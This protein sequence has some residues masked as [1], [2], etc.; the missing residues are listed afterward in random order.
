MKRTSAIAWL[1]VALCAEAASLAATPS[2]EVTITATSVNVAQPGAPVTIRILRWSTDAERAPI[3]NALNPPAAPA[4]PARNPGP[5]DAGRGRA[6]RGRGRGG[7]AATPL[8]PIAAFAAALGRA[9]TI[10]YIWT[11]DITGYSIKYAWHSPQPDGTD[12]IVVASDRRLGAYT[13]AWRFQAAEASAKAAAAPAPETDYGFTLIELRAGPKGLIEGKTSLTNK[14]AVD[15]DA[16]T[17]AL[18][19]YAAATTTLNR[20]P[21]AS[22]APS[23]PVHR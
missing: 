10:G 17:I 20:K 7:A 19:N 5:T 23:Q 21:A 12:R 11:S 8:S 1:A 18:E 15:A 4:T 2:D 3:L 13:D 9:P 6:G 22:T 14:I 16:K